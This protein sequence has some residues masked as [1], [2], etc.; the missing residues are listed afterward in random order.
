MHQQHNHGVMDDY[1]T[2][3]LLDHGGMCLWIC[4]ASTV[5]DMLP[6][7]LFL[8]LLKKYNFKLITYICS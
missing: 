1:K 3:H 7:D 6:G 2:L 8:F 4:F 5:Q